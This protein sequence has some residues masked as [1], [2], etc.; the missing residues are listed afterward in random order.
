M[1]NRPYL[2]E[3]ARRL[4]YK[5]ERIS[6][7]SVWAHR[8]SGHRGALL[9]LL[10]KIESDSTNPGITDAERQSD[11]IRLEDLVESGTQFLERAAREYYKAPPK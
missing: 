10:E 5:L 11:W 6:A 3:Q 9:K 4:I 8:S 1:E 7:D 2:I